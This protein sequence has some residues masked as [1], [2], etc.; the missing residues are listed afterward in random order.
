M[1]HFRPGKNLKGFKHGW[2][3]G[4]WCDSSW[5]LAFIMYNLDHNI[6]FE[7]NAQGFNYW[8]N[9]NYRRFYPDFIVNGEYIEIK[10]YV[11]EITEAK[12]QWFPKDLTLKVLYKEDME[13]YLKYAIET[14]GIDFWR[15][16]T[17]KED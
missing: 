6:E 11:N 17:D 9:E 4:Y 10:G 8:C 14:Y 3:K 2:Y 1:T 13:P 5:E 15:L 7:R 16:L 12:I